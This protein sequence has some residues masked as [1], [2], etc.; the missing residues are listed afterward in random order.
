M[1]QSKNLRCY[2]ASHIAGSGRHDQGADS[3]IFGAAGWHAKYMQACRP[4]YRF[5]ARKN[6]IPFHPDW[7]V[8]GRQ[9]KENCN[10]SIPHGN[11]RLVQLNSCQLLLT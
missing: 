6:Q 9:L 8:S 11:N 5:H 4:K 3:P 10:F 2:Q 1:V 7:S